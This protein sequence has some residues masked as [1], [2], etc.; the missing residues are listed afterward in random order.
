MSYQNVLRQIRVIIYRLKRQY[1][2]PVQIKQQ[3]SISNNIE[4]GDITRSFRTITIK[5]GI[6]LPRDAMSKFSYDL[7]YIAAN[8]NFTYGG[9]YDVNSRT[10][11]ID[12]KD[13]PTGTTLTT[14]DVVIFESRRYSVSK[15]EKAEHN[16]AWLLTIKELTSSDTES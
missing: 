12:V 10:M 5:R 15:L 13:L 9:F 6:L 7:S 2:L 1:G 3:L 8:K 14:E 16:K 4:T 11:I